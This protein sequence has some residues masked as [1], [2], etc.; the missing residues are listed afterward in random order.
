MRKYAGMLKKLVFTLCFLLLSCQA[1]NDSDKP[2]LIINE[3]VNGT[4]NS[5]DPRFFTLAVENEQFKK[6]YDSLY[7]RHPFKDEELFI[8]SM[9]KGEPLF[10]EQGKVV[11]VEIKPNL[12]FHDD[13]CFPDGKGR[14]VT[15]KDFVFSYLVHADPNNISIMWGSL[16]GLFKGVDEWRRKQKEVGTTDFNDPVTGIKILSRYKVRLELKQ[17]FLGFKSKFTV[18][19]I[20]I[21]PREAISFY[22][23]EFAINPV[24][25]GP[26]IFQR[27]FV[28][29]KYTF[30]KNRNYQ[31]KSIPLDSDEKF[32]FY[33]KDQI[34]K[35]DIPYVDKVV[36]HSFQ[37]PR[38]YQLNFQK[39][40]IDYMKASKNQFVPGSNIGLGL[41]PALKEMG[42]KDI[43]AQ[44]KH[45]AWLA[46]QNE[47]EFL[48]NKNLRKAISF[49]F[50]VEDAVKKMFEG[51]AI[52]AS[53]FIPP[54]WQNAFDF[55]FTY[56]GFDKTKA[57]ELLKEAGYP[58]G[59]G[60]PEITLNVT[61]SWVSRQLAEFFLQDMKA[62]GI[63]VKYT[64]FPYKELLKNNR[65]KTF[66]IS[67]N[68]W[69]VDE[70][71]ELFPVFTTDHLLT[72]HNGLG[73][74]YENYELHTEA[75]KFS[76]SEN[77]QKIAVS[78][79]H[80]ILEKNVAVIPLFHSVNKSLF[81][82]KIK[83]FSPYGSAAYFFKEN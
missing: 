31:S 77:S 27:P 40:E 45:I 74:V 5:F 15:I 64:Q 18:S 61:N 35:R 82:Y 37:E 32:F 7:E 42:V 21:I 69:P 30:I 36:V 47:F 73:V 8:P 14:E 68:S 71:Y 2:S 20:P 55:K 63:K 56:S 75:F 60:L 34:Q 10:L 76:T 28:K 81:H 6:I 79:I 53:H 9:A 51:L 25:S 3:G 59:K 43:N 12:F 57:L 72:G 48:R 49:G 4:L 54:A 83:N 41:D 65:N 80:N 70:L 16:S 38:T 11:E 46:F 78:Q 26:F 67:F 1:Q 66:M 62:I 39:G 23:D 17:P 24:G 50:D 52:P 22:G 19:N 29:N 44:S 33:S 58:N 13:K